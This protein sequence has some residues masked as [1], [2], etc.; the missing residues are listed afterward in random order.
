MDV[1]MPGKITSPT[2][3]RPSCMQCQRGAADYLVC[4]LS[5][6][7]LAT[8]TI[9]CNSNEGRKAD[10]HGWTSLRTPILTQSMAS[11][12]MLLH[13]LEELESHMSSFIAPRI[14]GVYDP[15]L[16]LEWAHHKFRAFQSCLSSNEPCC[17]LCYMPN[18]AETFQS[19]KTR[20]SEGPT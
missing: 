17:G 8:V 20:K 4:I 13:G 9:S 6:A 15:F 16:R 5:V 2:I 14:E 7:A 3:P 19:S 10:C 12:S 11:S 18:A 1:M